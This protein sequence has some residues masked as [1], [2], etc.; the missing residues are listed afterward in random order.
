VVA[1]FT[2]IPQTGSRSTVGTGLDGFVDIQAAGSLGAE[3]HI[4]F[5][6]YAALKRRSS[7]LLHATSSMENALYWI[8]T[9]RPAGCL[10]FWAAR[11]I[12]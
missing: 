7:T 4:I 6:L 12:P 10:H 1:E 9:R 3:A 11:I 5:S 2:L 8:Q